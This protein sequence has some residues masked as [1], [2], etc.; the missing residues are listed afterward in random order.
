MPNHVR[1]QIRE[2][3]VVLVT[4]LTTTGANVFDSRI[5]PLEQSKL[6]CLLVYAQNEEVEYLTMTLGTRRQDRRLEI[7][8]EGVAQDLTQIE[9]TLDTIAKEVETAIAGDVTLGGLAKETRLEDT[10]LSIDGQCE[11]PLGRVQ[12][13][14]TVDY[15][16]LENAPT[17]SA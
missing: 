3:V 11:K 16:T 4:S 13:T 12:M 1:Q 5:R 2:A 17:S 8:V 15:Q 10:E 9:D 14:F 6:P 7:I